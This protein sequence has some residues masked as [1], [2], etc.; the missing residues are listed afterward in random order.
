ML[1]V[2]RPA[3]TPILRDD[4][5][6]LVGAGEFVDAV[7]PAILEARHRVLL[8][9][10]TFEL[11]SVGGHFW[12]LLVRSPA[13]E[14]VLCVDAFSTAK[15]SDDLVCSPRYL[16]DPAF[17]REVRETRRLL[18]RTVHEGVR[19]VVTNPMGFLW[20]KFPVR[21]HKKMMIVDDQCFLGGINLSEHNFEWRDMMVRSDC[22][23][24]VDELVADFRRT[25][26]GENASRVRSTSLGRL[27]LLDGRRSRNEYNELFGVM[28]RA[29][30]TVD[31]ITPYVSEPLLGRL[32][33]LPSSVRVRIINPAPTNK[34][35]LQQ[36]LFKA[37]AGSNLEVLLYQPQMSH[38]KAVLVDGVELILG[39]CNFDF[40]AYDL[41]Q[42]VVLCTTDPALVADF[43]QRVLEPMVADSIPAKSAPAR[44]YHRAGLGVPLARWYIRLLSYLD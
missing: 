27:F 12:D 42:E 30:E 16:L 26:S 6:L 18:E 34:A 15:I 23:G 20:R 8:Q 39:S 7:E 21:N 11:D 13:R 41:Q 35:V 1:R 14:K 17:R 19:I 5:R 29:R 28:E 2:S 24:L 9:V 43:H 25:V 36:E 32:A 40:V 37:A 22:A 44:F 4:S 38:I 33:A 31:V 3:D 10:M